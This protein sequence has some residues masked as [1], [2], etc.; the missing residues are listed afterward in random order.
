VTVYQSAAEDE[1]SFAYIDVSPRPSS[2]Q[3]VYQF[4][5]V[6][7][8]VKLQVRAGSV[9]AKYVVEVTPHSV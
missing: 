4:E 8:W 5:D 7:Y 3:H 1:V 2:S 9:P 6:V